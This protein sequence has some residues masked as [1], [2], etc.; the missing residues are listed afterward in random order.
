LDP[1]PEVMF[2]RLPE[3]PKGGDIVDHL[4]CILSNAGIDWNGFDTVPREP[5]DDLDIRLIEIIDEFT[6]DWKHKIVRES[7]PAEP[8]PLR[9][10]VLPSEPYPVEAMGDVLCGAAKA[11]QAAVQAPMALCAQSVL[12]AGALAVQGH[13]DIKE[14][15]RT[16]PTSLYF[17]TVGETGERKSQADR[18]ALAPVKKHQKRLHN[19]YLVEKKRYDR[20]CEKY[21]RMSKKE[22]DDMDPPEAPLLPVLITGDPTL[23]GVQKQLNLGLPTLGIFSDEGGKVVGG[24]AMKAENILGTISGLSSFWDGSSDV[25][26]RAGD[27]FCALYGKRVSLHLMLQPIVAQIVLQSDLLKAQG[28]LGRCLV[29]YPETTAGT[30]F[31]SLG[32]H[33]ENVLQSSEMRRYYAI[34]MEMLERPLPLEEGKRNQL[35][36]RTLVLDSDSSRLYLEFYNAVEKQLG[37]DGPYSQIRGFSNRIAEHALRLAGVLQAFEDFSEESISTSVMENAIVLARWY[38]NEA[39]RLCEESNVSEDVILAEKLLKWIV[40]KSKDIVTLREI[41]Q[42]GPLCVRKAETAKMAADVLVKHGYLQLNLNDDKP[43][44]FSA[45]SWRVRCA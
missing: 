5:G 7:E 39:L 36:P 4:Q 29:T 1:E 19:E 25:K 41:Y 3:L 12:A 43:W 15:F 23:E 35:E 33:E 37:S 45:K 13:V 24:Y 20:A 34:M 8:L 6:K 17:I 28:F 16:I 11:I 26:V 31:R 44:D 2:S 14:G 40:D 18:L 42:Y 32:G 30:R 9:P 27:G 22:S 10:A 21:R 38:L